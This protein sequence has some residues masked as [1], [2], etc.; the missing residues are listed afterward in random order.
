[1]QTL[2]RWVA[3]WERL[4]AHAPALP[5][6][7]AVWNAYAEPQRHYH[8]QAHLRDCLEQWDRAPHL[9][10][11]PA[12]VEMALWFHD[13]IYDPRAADNEARSAQWAVEALT[14]ADVASEVVQRIAALV[15]VTQHHACPSDDD[16]RLLVDIDLSILGREPAVFDA[17]EQQIRA[18]YAWVPEATFCQRRGAIL[19][20]FLAR[21]T[22]YETA[23]FRERYE[24]QAR[25]NLARSL[26]RLQTG[27]VDECG[28]R[29][30]R[31][32]T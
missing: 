9:A 21:P 29:R 22:L 25:R 32:G 19:Q 30:K 20:A 17:Y 24:G 10:Q 23:L 11:R 26:V 18:E 13:A 12:E 4:G 3:L 5:V 27:R 15:L 31:A 1:M 28:H 6:Y 16:A 8:T 7:D 2:A 14:A